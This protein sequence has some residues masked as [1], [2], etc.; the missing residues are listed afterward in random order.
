MEGCIH[1]PITKELTNTL[2]YHAKD[3]ALAMGITMR[4]KED[5]FSQEKV[6]YPPITLLASPVPR[7]CFLSAE[8]IQI[9]FNSLMHHVAHDYDFLRECLKD[10]VKVDEFTRSLWDIYETVKAEGIA[11]P[12]SL[13]LNR[14]DY[15]F[16]REKGSPLDGLASISIKQVEFNTMASSFGGLCT[17]L[18]KHHAY[19]SHI[20][21]DH[22]YDISKDHF[23]VNEAVEGLAEGIV[24]A[25][26][27][28]G[29]AN[30][31]VLFMVEEKERN[32]YDQRWIEYA[33]KD[34]NSKVK[35]VRKSLQQLQNHVVIDANKN[36]LL[37]GEE[38]AVVY[39]R[40]TYH[41]SHFLSKEDWVMRLLIE[42]SRAIKCP[43]VHYF[44]A[45]TK[46]VQQ[47][48][49]CPQHLSRF[50]KDPDVR[51]QVQDTFVGQYSLNLGSEGD[52]AVA[53]ARK[54]PEGYVVKPQREGGGNNTFGADI[55]VL[56]KNLE[57][58]E[59]RNAYILME[60]IN[61]ATHTAILLKPGDQD[62]KPEEVVSELGIFGIVVGSADNIILNKQRG[63]ILRTKTSG[64]DEGGVAA[65]FAALDSPY[66]V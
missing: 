41:P 6:T 17:R 51:L 12:I 57:T 54:N 39:F 49:A 58:S 27:Q 65:G 52:E 61:P 24:C 35:V 38:V 63:H 46:K 50:I 55:P 16:H 31:I 32:V 25:W 47:M 43:S 15:M 23:P 59:E 30:A 34:Q 11:Q 37:D 44:L 26:E 21:N 33:I 7:H 8:R 20:L 1:F 18:S 4:Q 14:S 10:T 42:R 2:V 64:T 5:A 56:L 36:M 9:D 40:M 66:L 29:R 28:Y 19:M 62:A 53:M 13:A 48:L 45:G 3:H 60:R 22:G